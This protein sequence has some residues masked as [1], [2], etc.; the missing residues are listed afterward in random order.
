MN[1]I[2]DHKGYRFFQAQFDRDEK[3][4]ILSVS[5]D[6]WGT[7][8]TYFGYFLLYFALMAIM[9]DKNTRFGDLKKQ[10]DK[11][12]KKKSTVTIIALLFFSFG[13]IAQ[14]NTETETQEATKQETVAQKDDHAGHNHAPDEEHEHEVVAKEITD[15]QIDSIIAT[16]LVAKEHAEKF[17]RLVIQDDDGRMKPANTFAQELLRKLS[18]SNTYNDSISANQVL[19]SMIQYPKLWYLSLIHI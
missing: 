4:T 10:L 5:H 15:I 6:Y 8:I 3:G 16:N 17:G 13:A 7:N 1:H 9:F 12:K 2:M 11:I 19:L 14:E 18:K